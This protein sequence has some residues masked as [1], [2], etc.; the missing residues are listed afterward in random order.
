MDLLIYNSNVNDH[1]DNFNLL[2]IK[3]RK[4]WNCDEGFES[5]WEAVWPN[6]Q[7]KTCPIFPKSSHR[8]FA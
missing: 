5:H 1:D 7:I 8:S 6:I 3:F 4:L 2:L